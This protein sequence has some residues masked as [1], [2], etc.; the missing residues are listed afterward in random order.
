MW[1]IFKQFKEKLFLSLCSDVNLEIRF[2]TI[3]LS[4][5]KEHQGQTRCANSQKTQLENTHKL[6]STRF[7]YVLY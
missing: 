2:A 5:T 3:D 7:N 4:A 1:R 6:W